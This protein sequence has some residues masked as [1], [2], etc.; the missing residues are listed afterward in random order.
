MEDIALSGISHQSKHITDGSANRLYNSPSGILKKL[1]LTGFFLL[2]VMPKLLF[3][4]AISWTGD[5]D[6]VSWNNA[7]NWS[8]NRVPG[9]EDD[10]LITLNGTYTVEQ[11]GNVTVNSIILGAEEGT[12]TLRKTASSFSISAESSIGPNG[13]LLMENGYIVGEGSLTNNGII[14]ANSTNWTGINSFLLINEGI[15]EQIAGIFYI[16]NAIFDNRAR[17]DIQGDHP[18]F[19]QGSSATFINSGRLVKT[20]SDDGTSRITT[21]VDSRPESTIESEQGTLQIEGASSYHNTLFK[22]DQADATI[23]LNSGLHTFRGDISGNPVGLVE[24]NS[25]ATAHSDGATLNF[26]GTGLT[27]LS[28]YMIE[29]GEM[30]ND[31]L[32]RLLSS[33]WT[34]IQGRTLINNGTIEQ[35]G[36]IFYITNATFDNRARYDIQGDHPIFQ[37][38]S[39]ATFIN[40]GHLVK[41][42]SDDGTSRITTAFDSRLGSTI[43]SDAGL[44]QFERNGVHHN[45]ALTVEQEGTGIR[46]HSGVHT[47]RGVFTEAPVGTIT[48]NTE[49]KADEAGAVFNFTGTGLQWANQYLTAGGELRNDGLIVL[50]SPSFTGLNNSR[51]INNGS[52]E[53]VG[54]NFY[55]TNGALLENNSEFTITDDISIVSFSGIPGLFDN[56]GTFLKSGGEGLSI[57]SSAF[58]N[59]PGTLMELVTGEVQFR[60]EFSHHPDARLR[61]PGGIDV[62]RTDFINNGILDPG[63]SPSQ[64]TYVGDYMPNDTTARLEIFIGETDDE[65]QSSKLLIKQAGYNIGFRRPGGNAVLGGELALLTNQNYIPEPGDEFEVIRADLQMSGG[66]SVLE[67]FID[68]TND[69]TFYPQFSD[70]SLII[71]AFE[72]VPTISGELTAAPNELQAGSDG[73]IEM[74]G[75]G[76]SPDMTVE[77]TCVSCNA[78]DEFGTLR[79]RVGSIAPD[80]A[81]VWFDI[82]SALIFGNYNL[83]VS[84]P[85]GGSA[86]TQIS[87]SQAPLELSVHILKESTQGDDNTGLFVIRANRTPF[88]SVTLPYSLYGSAQQ[89]VHY[90]TD[91]L[92]GT[93]QFPAGADS[94]VVSVLPLPFEGSSRSV[95]LQI[96]SVNEQSTAAKLFASMTITASSEETAFR[97]LNFTPR[98]GGNVGLTTMTVTGAGFSNNTTVSVSGPGSSV[99][100]QGLEINETGT[101]LETQL[102]L[103]GQDLG[104]RDLIIQNGLGQEVTILNAFTIEGGIY[105][106]VFVQVFAPVRVPRVRTRSYKIILQNQGNVDVSGYAVLSGFPLNA[107]WELVDGNVQRADGSTVQWSSVVPIREENNRM[108]FELPATTLPAGGSRTFE[109]TA[110]I[111]Q[112]VNM[113]LKAAWI[114]K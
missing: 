64:F 60:G 24:L 93:I 87:I 66:F 48:I 103:I 23:R 72:G 69:V 67:N 9:A 57:F 107:E 58:N 102:N 62:A 97:V 56:H 42:A 39:S 21:A 94:V 3:G 81:G 5:G 84:D 43:Q 98:Q 12:Q 111:P 38:G 96:E 27:W 77:L 6:G 10:V 30:I 31:G 13:V 78:P 52:I 109:I 40:S 37:Q 16:T 88:E 91:L 74:S 35:L 86:Q 54:G 44:I 28:N 1:L 50:D 61:G 70:T 82:S 7:A 101:K 8:E 34:G 113:Q 68:V 112:A 47:F 105:P 80:T 65:L 63:P 49:F 53:H 89:Y 59:Q 108:I 55:V 22:V 17:Y 26:G 79:G 71:T 90:T 19:R 85:R 33:N 104:T 76:F 45:P 2:L 95:G 114:Y 110:A 4:Q 20:A 99:V 25:Q 29:G 83:T 75:S 51:L 46:F 11:T 92:G 36:G 100:S 18:I 73:K 14:R 41:T 106:D 15:M 32:I